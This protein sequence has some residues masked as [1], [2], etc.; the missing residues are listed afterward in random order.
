MILSYVFLRVNQ[1]SKFRVRPHH[2]WLQRLYR[3][4]ITSGMQV[5]IEDEHPPKRLID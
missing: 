2:G 1:S 5:A 3:V 4:A